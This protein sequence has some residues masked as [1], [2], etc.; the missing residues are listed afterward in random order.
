MCNSDIIQNGTC[1]AIFWLKF[2]STWGLGVGAEA[3]A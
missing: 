1:Y 2:K 3:E